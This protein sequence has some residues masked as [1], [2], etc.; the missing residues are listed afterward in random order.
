MSSRGAFAAALRVARKKAKARTGLVLALIRREHSLPGAP[1]SKTRRSN[2]LPAIVPL[3]SAREKSAA[4]GPLGRRAR[5]P[6]NHR[7][8][9]PNRQ[10]IFAGEEARDSKSLF[11]RHARQDRLAV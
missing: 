7:Q 4:P 10:G 9:I 6:A 11:P 1:T 2:P 5:L 8:N 3:Q